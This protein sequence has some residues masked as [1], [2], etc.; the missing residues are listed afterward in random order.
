MKPV[1]MS[2]KSVDS[3]EKGHSPLS[4]PLT[5]VFP[6]RPKSKTPAKKAPKC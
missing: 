1:K 5:S 3:M 2:K 4:K 6:A